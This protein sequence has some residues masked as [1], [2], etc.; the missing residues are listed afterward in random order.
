MTYA[1]TESLI[2]YVTGKLSNLAAY[3][4]APGELPAGK[5]FVEYFLYENKAGY[6][7]HFATAAT[8]AFRLSGIPA[9]YVEGYVINVADYTNAQSENGRYSME[10]KDSDSH[11]WV[12]L[13]LDGFGW[14]PVEVTPGFTELVVGDDALGG[15]LSEYEIGSGSELND[16]DVEK[17]EISQ[18]DSGTAEP[19][20]AA[21]NDEAIA[22]TDS[23]SHLLFVLCL[24]IL[25]V[26]LLVAGLIIR[27]KILL[28]KLAK[29]AEDS[30]IDSSTLVL[31]SHVVDVLKLAGIDRAAYY[32]D[33][34]YANDAGKLECVPA[35]KMY[36]A[37][38][39]A[40]K[41]AL[42]PDGVGDQER[43]EVTQL[44]KELIENIYSEGNWVLKLKRKRQ[45]GLYIAKSVCQLYNKTRIG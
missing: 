16:I 6:C 21:E 32:S 17:P 23:K 40:L 22:E 20:Q 28:F 15:T 13:Y 42:G 12:E 26:V 5:D 45:S 31:Y 11:A 35:E 3:T 7:T 27:R 14:V 1:N 36:N 41:A 39:I 4:L 25:L 10:I 24:G 29:L 43:D 34:E 37:S 18:E 38:A 19:D 44:L 30:G 33:L 8:L 9:R 2:K